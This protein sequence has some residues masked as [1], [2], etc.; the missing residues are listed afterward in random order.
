[1]TRERQS[2]FRDRKV[3][4]Q[5]RK[6]GKRWLKERPT[7][8]RLQP[9]NPEPLNMYQIWESKLPTGTW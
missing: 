5:R 7:I 9:L 6:A 1:V 4:A 2:V 3:I 8:Q